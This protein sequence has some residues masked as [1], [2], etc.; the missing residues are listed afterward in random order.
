MGKDLGWVRSDALLLAL[1][2]HFTDH[3]YHVGSSVAIEA[4]FE[5]IGF[6]LKLVDLRVL[7]VQ[8]LD[9]PSPLVKDLL[10]KP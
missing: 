6:I 2:P 7:G 10:V 9:S 1:L 5:G 8:V 3:L 4:G